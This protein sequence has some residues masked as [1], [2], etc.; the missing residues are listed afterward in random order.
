MEG[1]AEMRARR[2]NYQVAAAAPESLGNAMGGCDGVS[3]QFMIEIRKGGISH[4]LDHFFRD[5]K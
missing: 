2:V 1:V 4:H 5:L 3:L